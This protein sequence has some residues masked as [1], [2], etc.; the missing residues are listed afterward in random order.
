MFE[1]SKTQIYDYSKFKITLLINNIYF[2]EKCGTLL[3]KIPIFSAYTTKAHGTFLAF[4]S[5][6]LRIR[7]HSEKNNI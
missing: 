1:K 5:N 4:N 6:L 3:K 2:C 7:V